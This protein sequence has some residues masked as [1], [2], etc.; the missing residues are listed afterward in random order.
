MIKHLKL[1]NFR[2][3]KEYSLS[4]DKTTVLIGK[5]GVGKTNILESIT[6]VS[7]GKS[8]REDERKNL[9]NYG[10]DWGRVIVDDHE[11]FLQRHPKL[12]TK[13]KKRGVAKKMSEIIGDNPAIVFSPETMEV[14]T[15]E[16]TKRRKFL[17]IMIS[18]VDRSYLKIISQY[19]K[20]RRQR[21]KLLEMVAEGTA[22]ENELDYWDEQII[23][24]GQDIQNS[25]KEAVEELAP[26]INGYHITISGEKNISLFTNYLISGGNNFRQNFQANRK[27]DIASRKT[28]LGPHRDDLKFY[29]NNLDMAHYASRGEVRSAILAT[30]LAE[31]NYIK[32]MRINNPTIYQKEQKPILLL[33]DVYSEFD[34]NRRGHLS[35][36]INNH[37]TLI[38][39]TDIN[40]LSPFLVK[41]AKIIMINKHQGKE[42]K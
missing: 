14:I 15:G 6:L 10:S 32:K 31:I 39:T 28:N 18:Q 23:Q 5:N 19:T 21:N 42:Q 4:L 26:E 22:K 27:K 24:L 30:K 3:H 13:I 11:I 33:D 34:E 7:F 9:I 37:Q 20:V 25:R 29:L 41:K 35:E 17:D 40:H 38:T 36:I 8:F 12:L 2:N 1:E 16:P